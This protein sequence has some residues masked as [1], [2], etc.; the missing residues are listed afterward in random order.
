[1]DISRRGFITVLGILPLMPAMPPP[2]A[3]RMQVWP[4]ALATAARSQVGVTTLYD[5][6][7]IR[8]DYPMGDVPMDRGVC[9]DV[10]VRAY[11]AAFGFDFQRAIHEDM[12]AN[13][14]AYPQDWGLTAPDPN[15]D[16]RR[17]PNIE[18]WLRRHGHSLPLPRLSDGWQAG[19]LMTCRVNGRLPHIGI[20]SDR[21]SRS[22]R[23]LVLHN[24]GL[25][26]REE[27]ILGIH[28]NEARFRFSPYV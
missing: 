16:H 9:I 18:S 17:V 7:Y 15:I 21:K 27:D 26:T 4:M 14:A 19:D 8:L 24:I 5:P 22:G 20:V 11:R 2:L 12:R 1:M 23:P 28:P 13:F 25:G 6:E 3:L 10:V